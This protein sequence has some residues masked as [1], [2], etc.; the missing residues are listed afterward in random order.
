V[1]ESHVP[2]VLG[3]REQPQPYTI[4]SRQG[5]CVQLYTSNDL[6]L[7][8]NPNVPLDHANRLD[9]T[10]QTSEETS[11]IS[12]HVHLVRFDELGSDGTSVGWNYVQAAMPGQTYG[13]RWFVDQPLRTV[14]FH[15]HQYANLHQQKGLFAAM[16]VEPSD[17]TWTDPVTGKPTD[18]TGPMA[19][20][21]SS[22]G[23]HFRE[24]TLFYSDRVPMWKDG[25]TGAA[26]RPP[27]QVNN[28]GSDQG[29]YTI[30]YRNEPM[31]TR[32]S[33]GAPGLKDDPAYVYSS[34]VH[35]D[36]STPLLKA[37]SGDPVVIRQ[38]TGAHEEVHN[39]TLPGHRWL[40][41]PD[42]PNSTMTD[43][44]GSA[45]AEYFNYEL[46]SGRP[47]KRAKPVNQL[48]EEGK[49][50]ASNGG[51]ALVVN[52]AGLPGDYQYGSTALDD[53]WLG[54]WGIFRTADKVQPDLAPLPD[55]K[56]Y[57]KGQSVAGAAAGTAGDVHAVG[58][59][60]HGQG[61]GAPLR[62]RGDG[63]ADHLQR[64]D[65][66]QRPGR[67]DVRA[68]LGRGSGTVRS[69][70]AQSAGAAGVLRGLPA[71]DTDQPL[72]GDR[73]TSARR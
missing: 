26:V 66:Q 43:I 68:G 15:D 6:H 24:F 55:R 33:P 47:G 38:V 39:F 72:P 17:A 64:E 37:Y 61:T 70:G 34:A 8:E 60:V 13:Y 25:G 63:E 16:N 32:T 29:G 62:H 58:S 59:A 22:L 19:D 52:G 57:P 27:L 65:R 14:F 4:R 31:E 46:V 28:F 51:P 2:A 1:E 53:Q 71:S 3:K 48:R 41:E 18:G 10:Y 44:Q 40:N 20:I 73:A 42:N 49:V 23:P 45:L 21:H 36:P 9:G 67:R 56:A 5:D 54:M 7:D 12:T 11:E 50:N 69:E 35:G 30:N